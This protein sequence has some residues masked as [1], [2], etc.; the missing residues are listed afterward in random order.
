MATRQSTTSQH[1]V[2]NDRVARVLTGAVKR[3]KRLGGRRASRDVK[4][5]Y[6]QA[7]TLVGKLRP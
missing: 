7:A 2:S 5:A 6:Q 3:L 4:A 1:A